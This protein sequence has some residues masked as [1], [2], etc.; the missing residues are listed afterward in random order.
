MGRVAERAY[1][2]G[3]AELVTQASRL[4]GFDRTTAAMQQRIA[5]I[6]RR[7]LTQGKLSTESNGVVAPK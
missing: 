1:G 3:E 7:T 2:A 6:L 4:L 5:G